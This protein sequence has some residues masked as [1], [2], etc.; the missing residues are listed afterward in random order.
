MQFQDTQP[1][2]VGIL[3]PGEMGIAVAK[4]LMNRQ[5]HVVTT[6]EDRS[7]RTGQFAEAAG[8]HIVDSLADV[9]AISDIVISL[10][11]PAA[12]LEVATRYALCKSRLPTSPLFVDANSISPRTAQR[13]GKRI[14]AA[15][16]D[17]VDAAIHGLA[18]RLRDHG[19][20][21]LSGFRSEQVAALFGSS[22]QSVN[23]GDE[24]GTASML[25][26]LMGGFSKGLVS[27][28]LEMALAAQKAGL[29]F[30]F[31]GGCQQYYP[32]VMTILERLLPTYPRHALRR[33][34]EVAELKRTMRRLDLRPGVIRETERL[35]RSLGG[36]NL[37]RRHEERQSTNAAAPS[38]AEL[39]EIISQDNLLQPTDKF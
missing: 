4:L 2:T 31:L 5:I 6:L 1:A 32:G 35:L 33:A 34:D 14:R 29:L 28:F 16:A 27:L 39:I 11:S 37:Q 18:S 20:L 26:M 17:F 8:L 24:I 22:L 9:A 19:T 36:S 15:G 12:A 13:I 10:V 23:L 25:K 21:Y 30:E 38:I 3:F 7:E